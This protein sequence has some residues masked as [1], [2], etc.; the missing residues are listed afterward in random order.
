MKRVH[1]IVVILVALTLMIPSFSSLVSAQTVW[2]D[3]EQFQ[4]VSSNQVVLFNISNVPIPIPMDAKDINVTIHARFRLLRAPDIV[5]I[6]AFVCGVSNNVVFTLSSSGSKRIILNAHMKPNKLSN[7]N[8]TIC[9]EDICSNVLDV[10]ITL[11]NVS[12][13]DGSIKISNAYV[14]LSNRSSSLEVLIPTRD[15]I[16]VTVVYRR[17]NITFR[18]EVKN[19]SSQNPPQNNNSTPWAGIIGVGILLAIL[20]PTV[21][22][23]FSEGDQEERGR[24]AWQSLLGVSIVIPTW[25]FLNLFRRRDTRPPLTWNVQNWVRWWN[26]LNRNIRTS[27]ISAFVSIVVIVN[28]A[29][30]LTLEIGR[31][32]FLALLFIYS[33]F[34][35]PLTFSIIRGDD[36]FVLGVLVTLGILIV[37]LMLVLWGL[38]RSHVWISVGLS[39]LVVFGYAVIFIQIELKRIFMTQMTTLRED[40]INLN[41]RLSLPEVNRPIGRLIDIITQAI[42]EIDT[43]LDI[44]AGGV[45]TAGST[46]LALSFSSALLGSENFDWMDVIQKAIGS[47]F[48]FYIGILI[49]SIFLLRAD[50][51]LRQAR[52]QPPRLTLQNAIAMLLIVLGVGGFVILGIN[53]GMDNNGN[54]SLRV[55]LRWARENIEGIVSLVLLIIEMTIGIRILVWRANLLQRRRR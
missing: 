10:N 14:I 19:V 37:S 32:D 9:P 13:V 31:Q 50:D 11:V 7:W 24:V 41:N 21:A 1:A 22:F 4:V 46:V 20:I 25:R 28:I 43:F 29:I 49:L 36:G 53:F 18:N 42:D 34:G 8:V 40:L 2:R 12:P 16:G 27:L 39:I 33:V 55:L 30:L 47:I 35:V 45:I 3:G 44:L 23:L 17:E 5:N 6:R 54:P 15:F 38:F 52:F 51:V 26:N 48:I